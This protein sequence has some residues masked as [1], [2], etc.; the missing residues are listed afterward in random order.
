MPPM[1]PAEPASAAQ[2]TMSTS[3]AMR[4]RFA[5]IRLETHPVMSMATAVT[6]R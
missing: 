3:P 5:P 2:I 6:T 1:L 4:V